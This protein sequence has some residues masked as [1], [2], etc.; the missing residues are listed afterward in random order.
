M[1]N[2]VEFDEVGARKRGKPLPYSF[3]EVGQIRIFKH[4]SD[5]LILGMVLN[6]VLRSF[7]DIHFSY[8][9]TYLTDTKV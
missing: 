6:E 1:S 2:V 7:V 9:T 3:L 5:S 4:R 8:H